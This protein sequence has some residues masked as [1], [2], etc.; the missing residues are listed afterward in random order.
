MT[1]WEGPMELIYTPAGQHASSGSEFD[2]IERVGCLADL[3]RTALADFVSRV[4]HEIKAKQ[5][6]GVLFCSSGA[7]MMVGAYVALVRQATIVAFA[8]LCLGA[9]MVTI[10]VSRFNSELLPDL[11]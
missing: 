10:G 8:V 6:I 3:S 11:T 1:Y 9:V 5:A 2:P 4:E 7:M